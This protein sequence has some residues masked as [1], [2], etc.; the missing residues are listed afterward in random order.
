MQLKKNIRH[1]C[2]SGLCYIV[3]ERKHGD[4]MS[5]NTGVVNHWLA[6]SYQLIT[7]VM[8]SLEQINLANLSLDIGDGP[9]PHQGLLV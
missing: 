9:I 7:P 2:N 6:D 8:G 4:K 3:C 1:T 5:D